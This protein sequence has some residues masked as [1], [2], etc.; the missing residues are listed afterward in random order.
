MD[1][2]LGCGLLEN[3]LFM[4][5]RRVVGRLICTTSTECEALEEHP[6]KVVYASLSCQSMGMKT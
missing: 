3:L 2:A 5:I 4:K 1:Y 6:P